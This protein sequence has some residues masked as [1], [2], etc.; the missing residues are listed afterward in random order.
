VGDG[1][2]GGAAEPM[3][4]EVA[5]DAGLIPGPLDIYTFLMFGFVIAAVVMFFS[6]VIWFLGMPGKIAI[7][8][9]HPHAETVKLMGWAG[10]LAVVPW[11]HAFIWAYHDSMT[12]DIRRFPREE[13][14]VVDE[15]IARLTGEDK[16]TAQVEI[17]RPT[18]LPD[19]APVPTPE[20]S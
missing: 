11:I 20:A 9:H 12:V 1:G 7:A 16:K 2:N 18:V 5:S 10:A 6:I 15:E 4:R 17:D 13:K 14:K 19:P 3:I 8:R